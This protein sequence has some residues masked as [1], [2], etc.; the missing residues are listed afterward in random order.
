MTE[1]AG[2]TEGLSKELQVQDTGNEKSRKTFSEVFLP[3]A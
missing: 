3:A 2:K 1:Q